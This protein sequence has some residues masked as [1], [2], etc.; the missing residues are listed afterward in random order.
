MKK[1]QTHRKYGLFTG[2]AIV[3]VGLILYVTG[4]NFEKWA[5]YVMY[6]PFL[7]GL[8]LNA[9]AYAKANNNYVSYGNVFGSCFKT[10]AIV[11][12]IVLA[13]SFVSIFIFPDMKDKALEMAQKG[14][15]ENN[16]S[17]EQ[18]QQALDM[19]KKYFYPFMMGGI[20]FGYMLWGAILSAF[21][22][23][24][25]K[26]LGNQAPFDNSDSQQQFQH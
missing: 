11:T 10:A 24:F 16:M 13:W 2:L 15:L 7:L 1:V 23:I 6:A 18:I 22:A 17:D 3:I 26:K 8:I 9:H 20:I 19:T 4:N 25:P 5:Q 14:M 12:L 21:A